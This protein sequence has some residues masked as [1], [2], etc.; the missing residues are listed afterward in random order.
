VTLYLDTSAVVKLY[1]VEQGNAEVRRLVAVASHVVSSLITYVET[2]SALA[3]KYYSG[4]IV[5]ASF[6]AGKA[7]FEADWRIFSKM[8]P[9]SAI[10][11]RAGDLTEQFRLRAYNAIH[12]ATVERVSLETRSQVRF[13]CFDAALN[14]AASTLG[15]KPI[16]S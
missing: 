12:L 15:L 9:D 2:R 3:R 14:R 8:P 1:A 6:E 10:V 4:E 11:R 7:E 5:A 13:A 16:V